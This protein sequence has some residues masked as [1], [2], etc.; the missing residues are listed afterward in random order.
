MDR[1][2]RRAAVTPQ[3]PDADHPSPAAGRYSRAYSEH[4]ASTDETAGAKRPRVLTEPPPRRTLDEVIDALEEDAAREHERGVGGAGR[5][6]VVLCAYPCRR[7]SVVA[8]GRSRGH[9]AAR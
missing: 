9:L 2:H 3:V 6:R 1:V 4:D 7:V 5:A 8:V